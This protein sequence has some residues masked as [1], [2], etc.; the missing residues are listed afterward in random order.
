MTVF[1]TSS[2][3][4]I[5]RVIQVEEDHYDYEIQ[6]TVNLIIEGNYKKVSFKIIFLTFI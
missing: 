5:T 1:S 4:A 6:R 2:E 3:D